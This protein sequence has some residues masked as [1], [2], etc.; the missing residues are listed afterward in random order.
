MVAGAEAYRGDVPDAE[1]HLLKAGHFALDEAPEEVA[2][3]TS[4]FLREVN[5]DGRPQLDA[6][7]SSSSE[8]RFEPTYAD[9]I[10]RRPH[11]AR[12]QLLASTDNRSL[13][14]AHF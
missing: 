11:F 8:R 4:A 2:A 14:Y 1:V 3:L 7:T 12:H 9:R 6:S 13:C 5:G 10:S